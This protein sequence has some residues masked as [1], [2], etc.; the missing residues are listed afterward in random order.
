MLD[1]VGINETE[2]PESNKEIS[3][4]ALASFRQKIDFARD[5]FDQAHREADRIR[6]HF[7][8][9]AREIAGKINNDQEAAGLHTDDWQKFFYSNGWKTVVKI[10][11]WVGTTVAVASLFV[12]GRMPSVSFAWGSSSSC[13]FCGFIS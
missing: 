13:R 11:K 10:S 1:Y 9:K 3:E 5:D 12:S 4:S 8:D 6:Q 7:E 2:T